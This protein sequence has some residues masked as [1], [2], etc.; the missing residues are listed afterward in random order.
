MRTL[1][2]QNLNLEIKNMYKINGV[3]LTLPPNH[4]SKKIKI[5]KKIKK[6]LVIAAYKKKKDIWTY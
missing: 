2:M 3:G 5:K 4:F 1:I 6:I